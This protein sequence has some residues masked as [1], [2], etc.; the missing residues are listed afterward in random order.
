DLPTWEKEPI[1]KDPAAC[2]G[3]LKKSLQGTLPG[4]PTIGE[5]GRKFLADLLV[6]LSDK[7]IADMFTAARVD[8]FHEHEERNRPIADWVRVFKKKRDEVVNHHCPA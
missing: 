6:Q 8:H 4:N 1:W 5:A 3:N 2:V 7:Q